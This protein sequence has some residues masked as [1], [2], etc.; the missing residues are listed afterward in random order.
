MGRPLTEA[1]LTDLPVILQRIKDHP[2]VGEHAASLGGL[3]EM[4]LRLAVATT[5]EERPWSQELLGR[6]LAYMTLSGGDEMCVL[7]LGF[8]AIIQIA[9]REFAILGGCVPDIEKLR[10]FYWP[11]V[12]ELGMQ[13]K[14]CPWIKDLCERYKIELKWQQFEAYYGPLKDE[15]ERWIKGTQTKADVLEPG[16]KKRIIRDREEPSE[17]SPN[18]RIIRDR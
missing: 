12:Y 10:R 9:Q 7:N 13:G 16:F 2:W 8:N 15:T 18:R 4:H 1:E 11:R 17:V 14:T 5:H 3:Y 6:V